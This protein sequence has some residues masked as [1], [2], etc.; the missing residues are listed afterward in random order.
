MAALLQSVRAVFGN[1]LR[2]LEKMGAGI[3]RIGRTTLGRFTAIL[4][5]AP[6]LVPEVLIERTDD[7]QKGPGLRIVARPVL[8]DGL[9]TS[10]GE[11]HRQRRKLVAPAFAHHR[12]SKYASVMTEHALAAQAAWRDGERL[13]IAQVMMRLTLGIVGRTLFDVDLLDRADSLGRDIT[14][15]QRFAARQVR[16]GFRLPF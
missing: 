9:L 1:R 6:E 5:N 11:Q 8:G 3:P 14:T 15:V 12:V 4:V 2:M 10:E 16:V 13:D 7:F